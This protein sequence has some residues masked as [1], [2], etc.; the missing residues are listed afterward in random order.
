[1]PTKEEALLLDTEDMKFNHF[2]IWLIESTIQEATLRFSQKHPGD[3]AN[4]V[5]SGFWSYI[6]GKMKERPDWTPAIEDDDGKLMSRD[7]V[8]ALI[9]TR[10]ANKPYQQV[11]Q[12][13]VAAPVQQANVQ[14]SVG[15]AASW[16]LAKVKNLINHFPVGEAPSDNEF[17]VL[18]RNGKDWTLMTREGETIEIENSESK[19]AVES[20]KKDNKPVTSTNP[21]ELWRY[22]DYLSP[23]KAEEPQ[24]R[25][26]EGGVPGR[27]PPEKVTEYNKKIEDSFLNSNK[28]V[29]INALAG[30]GKT[31]MLKHLASFK[32]PGEKWLYLVFNKKNQT[33]AT[34]IDPETKLRPFPA[35]VDVLTTHAFLGRVL[36]SNAKS[37]RIDKT[38]LHDGKGQSP[39]MSEMLDDPWFD[40]KAKNDL[41][42]PW[43]RIFA[44][45]MRVKKLAS[46]GKSFNVNPNSSREA[47]ELLDNIID[48]YNIDTT[49]MSDDELEQAQNNGREIKDYRDEVVDMAYDLLRRMVPRGASDKYHN[50]VRDHDDTL[51]WAAMHADKL[52]FPHYDVVLADEVQDFN[53]NQQVMLR[54][55]HEAGARIIAVGDPSQAIYRFRGADNDAF[56]NVEGIVH[57]GKQGGVTHSL[58]INWRSGKKIIDYANKTTHMKDFPEDQRLKAGLGHDGEVT[59]DKSYADVIDNIKDE[60]D[61]NQKLHHPTAILARTNAPLLSTAM[62]LLKSGIPFQIVG[63][64]FLDEIMKFIKA[65]TG[66]GKRATNYNIEELREKI[67]AYVEEKTDA[68][69]GKIKKQ[70]ELEELKTIGD[71]LV[72]VL[73]YLEQH[74]WRD[75]LDKDGNV[76]KDTYTFMDFL[77]NRFGGLNVQDDAADADK[78]EKMKDKVVNITTG[79]RSK[80]LE[81]D[82]V[83]IIRNDLYAAPK[84]E[85]EEEI[86]QEKHGQYVAYTRAKKQLHVIND[87]NPGG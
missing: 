48:K 82:R 21:E 87:K 11:R 4:K 9:Q 22:A 42:I 64:E 74:E 81:F 58:P 63:R 23:N 33:E 85:N 39:K 83:Y 20:V 56:K 13:P 16:V 54:K 31:S 41:N 18:T 51:W 3:D 86:Q 37:G 55:L 6:I 60:W 32:K 73:T 25:T 17:V 30:T 28:N 27:L 5:P 72:G 14:A 2:T 76:I 49:L 75:P 59:E 29:V 34:K 7:A 67:G 65:V 35:G 47:M 45:K 66:V 70:D 84:G 78:F 57:D 8:V 24:A 77:R 26:P 10:A 68:W 19:D 43:K 38:E 79:H 52:T 40:Q 15:P 80:G 71:S 62:E 53:K 61:R 1:V 36:E 12:A 44:L 69:K 46:L 50:T